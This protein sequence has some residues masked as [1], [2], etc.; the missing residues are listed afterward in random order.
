M[1]KTT[2][3][4]FTIIWGLYFLGISIGGAWLYITR[5]REM[6]TEIETNLMAISQLKVSQVAQWRSQ[7]LNN[8]TLL[9]ESPFLAE[10]VSRWFTYPTPESEEAILTRLTSLRK[11]LQL[12]DVILLDLGGEVKLSASG[13]R[14]PLHR[15][16]LETLNASL[17]DRR[18]IMS[19]LHVCDAGPHTDIL[20]PLFAVG[21]SRPVGAILL[22]VDANQFLYP[23]IQSWPTSSTS[24]ET[25]LVRRDGD[26]VLFLNELRHLKNAAL[27]LR[28]PLSHEDVPAV[29]AV[30]GRE[31]LVEGKDYRGV[32]VFSA[33][34][35]IPDS[36]WFMVTK[37][38]ADEA[39]VLWHLNSAFIMTLVLG[40]IITGAACAGFFWQRYAK[41]QYRALYHAEAAARESEERYRVTLMSIGDAVIVTDSE[42]LVKLL[43]PVAEALTGWRLE[44][45]RGKPMAEV[46]HIVNEHTGQPVE[47]PVERI[48]R[49]GVVIGLANHTVLISRDGTQYPI[50]D[51]GAPIRDEVGRISGA[52]LVFRDQTE[53]RRAEEALRAVTSR[54]QALLAAIPDIIMEVDE[55]KVY[56]WANQAGYDFFGEDVI[57]KEAADYFEGEQYTYDVLQPLFD[58]NENVIYLE[59]WQR[60]RDGEKRLLAWWCRVL[61]DKSGRVSGAVSS[62]RDITDSW[63]VQQEK[64]KLKA[65]LRQAQRMEAIGTLAG[66][67]AH[68]FNNILAAIM[69][70]SE[71]VL[72]E[73]PEGSPARDDMEQV[74]SAAQRAKELVKQILTFS[75]QVDSLQRRPV[76]LR[77]IVGEALKLMRAALP[78]TIEL[79]KDISRSSG[80]ILGDPTQIHQV[81]VNLCTNA[82]HAMRA[83]G[84]VLEVRLEDLNLDSEMP[85]FYQD[86][87]PGAY[88]RL[89]V[90]DT[91]HGMDAATI[92]R[93]F[94]PYFTTKKTGEGTGLGLA[95]VHGIVK[96]H[97]GVI[98]LQSEPGKGTVFDIY[99][100]RIEI[101]KEKED[102]RSVP[103]PLGSERILFVDDEQPL[104][105]MAER[106]LRQLGYHVVPMANS[107]DA[108]ELFKSQPDGFDL[109]I[110]DYTMPHM[111]GADL[112]TKILKIR[113]EIPIILCTGFSESINEKE[114]IAMGI[115]E[116][117]MKPLDRRGIAEAIRRVMKRK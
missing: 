109:V 81:I 50:A 17:R 108:L 55:N 65:Q 100:P 45:A 103:L 85:G 78:T 8:A 92:E 27:Q 111:T 16:A 107:S 71:M 98:T 6:R 26:S 66:G 94:D 73:I 5:Q 96:R 39:M 14:E 28:I 1:K 41:A 116:F 86:L 22:K 91:G 89:T 10:G 40:L 52:V 44:E 11:C 49:E 12:M 35:A 97:K 62:A 72:D 106:M 13:R 77:V 47:D 93:I 15:D 60:R 29:M 3:R 4:W 112:A 115:R 82:A 74:L 64:E 76:E 61:K 114:A 99:F 31:G 101:R 7:H 117:V 25:L 88:I 102:H 34:K 80:V 54:Q 105:A 110:A 42:G 90:G 38:D 33:L 79:R 104:V 23:M 67:I 95:V 63:L 83:H 84:G 48:L 58:G 113:P 51:S 70:Y 2:L 53:E 19:D 20:A 69:G 75:R 46:F 36:P 87:G 59:S 37:I 21:G 43:N 68:D 30:L 9:T 56:T 24:A 57:G 32:H 18:P